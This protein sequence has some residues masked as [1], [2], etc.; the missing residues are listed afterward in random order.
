MNV[1]SFRFIA[2]GAVRFPESG[3]LTPKAAQSKF[4]SVWGGNFSEPNSREDF[5]SFNTCIKGFPPSVRGSSGWRQSSVFFSPLLKSLVPSPHHSLYELSDGAVI[6]RGTVDDISMILSHL[7]RDNKLG[8]AHHRNCGVVRR[9]NDLA[10]HTL[11]SQPLL[12]P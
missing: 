9:Q 1:N 12:F 5:L 6:D 3:R 8:I 2:E 7:Q 10:L 4:E 11:V